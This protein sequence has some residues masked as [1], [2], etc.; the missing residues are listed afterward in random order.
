ML[1]SFGMGDPLEPPVIPVPPSREE[2]N[3]TTAR[4]RRFA[5]WIPALRQAQGKLFAGMTV[6][7]NAHVSQMTPVSGC[8]RYL[9]K[10]E[11]SRIVSFARPATPAPAPR[12]SNTGDPL[13]MATG[14]ARTRLDLALRGGRVYVTGRPENEKGNS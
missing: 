5:E 9:C 7:W 11:E 3:P 8:A 14:L 12:L 13:A 6:A 4:F 1:V 10:L 2:S